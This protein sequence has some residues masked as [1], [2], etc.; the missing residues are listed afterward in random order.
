MEMLRI[1]SGKKV[2]APSPKSGPIPDSVTD[3]E[4][5]DSSS[6]RTVFPRHSST[7]MRKHLPPVILFF[8]DSISLL[9]SYALVKFA[10]LGPTSTPDIEFSLFVLWPLFSVIAIINETYSSKSIIGRNTG[11]YKPISSLAL[12]A[13]L[14]LSIA[15]FNKSSQDFSRFV[16]I[17]SIFIASISILSS[18]SLFVAWLKGRWGPNVSNCLV[19]QAGGPVL[20]LPHA[21]TVDAEELR[22]VPDIQDPS[23]LDRLALQFADMDEIIV[24]CRDS[25][26]A[27]WAEALKGSGIRGEIVSTYA[28]EVGALEIVRRT[29]PGLT[30]MLVSSGPLTLADRA[31]KRLFDLAISSV[32]IVAF[33]PLMGIIALAIRIDDGGPIFFRQR[34]MG[35]GNRFFEIFKFRSMKE[36]AADIDGNRS[37]SLSDERVTRVGQFI[38]KSSLDELPQL[39]NVLR[40]DMSIVGPRPHALGSR[41]GAKMFW[42]V[43]RRYWHRHSLRP[44]ITGLAQVR[45]LRGATPSEADLAERLQSDLEYLQGWTIFRDLRII[46][47]TLGVIFHRRAF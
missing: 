9:A 22:L 7:I 2:A 33:A 37:T 1:V 39:I 44:G 6:S 18:R 19:V 27:M 23:A 30:T 31:V 29:D 40:G 5:L 47:A 38:R 13:L 42:Q 41:A 8:L 32:A 43:D 12:A 17:I 36:E 11:L 34:R 3:G 21:F 16:F 45:G 26:R 24:S 15:F 46:I 28:H 10:Y 35:R 25:E 20:A 4:L 14:S